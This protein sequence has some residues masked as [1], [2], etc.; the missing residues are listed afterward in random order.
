A[1]GEERQQTSS[2]TA[3]AWLAGG[4]GMPSRSAASSDG[5]RPLGGKS[6]TCRSYESAVAAFTGN[7]V[8][9]R[10]V[11]CPPLPAS[12]GYWCSPA[13]E[14][15]FPTSPHE[16]HRLWSAYQGVPEVALTSARRRD[17]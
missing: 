14:P 11:S 8:Q 3:A 15:S 13:S 10:N 2:G 1:V 6:V 12:I 7:G 16:S 9:T 4:A 17:R 5:D